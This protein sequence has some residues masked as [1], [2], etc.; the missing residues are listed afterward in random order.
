MA[1]D[2]DEINAG[3]DDHDDDSVENVEKSGDYILNKTGFI[4]VFTV[5]L[6]LLL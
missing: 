4:Y 6:N 5:I 1:E 3:E 2:D